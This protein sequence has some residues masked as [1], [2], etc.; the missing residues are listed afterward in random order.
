[1]ILD[2]KP[3]SFGCTIAEKRSTTGYRHLGMIRVSLGGNK[4]DNSSE[5]AFFNCFV[6]LF[7]SIVLFISFVLWFVFHFIFRF[8]QSFS[9]SLP[10]QI[11]KL[12]LH[13]E[14]C[15]PAVRLWSPAPAEGG[16]AGK[17]SA[18]LG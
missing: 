7:Y 18:T 12:R 15:F 3:K 10:P 11:L 16:F 4:Y 1:M 5:S 6:L 14:A 13:E 8:S 2:E 9:T 17:R